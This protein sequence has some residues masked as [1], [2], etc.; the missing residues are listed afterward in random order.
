LNFV[1]FAAAA[2]VGV[3]PFIYCE[4]VLFHHS[5]FA[6]HYSRTL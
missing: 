1:L 3:R 2:D 4:P 6:I 5:L